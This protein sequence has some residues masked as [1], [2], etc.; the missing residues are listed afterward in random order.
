M[1]QKDRTKVIV[2]GRPHGKKGS[3]N[4]PVY[5]AST[6]LFPT[7]EEFSHYGDDW[8]T[9]MVYG[10]HG[11]PTQFALQEALAQ[12]EGGYRTWLLP[13]GLAAIAISLLAFVK[14]G[15]HLLMPDSVY[16]PTRRFCDQWLT[17]FGIN[18][19]Y[20]DPLIGGDIEGLCTARTSV[21]FVE[22]PGSLTF[23]VQDVP[24]IASAAHR[25][26]ATVLMDNTWATPLFFKPFDHGVDVSIQAATKYI[27]GHSDVMLGAITATQDAWPRIGAAV[28]GFGQQ[29][30]P[31]DCY[32]AL[33]GLRTL[34]VRL[35]RH[36]ATALTLAHW[37]T[38]QAQVA[39]IMHPA[40]PGCQGHDLWR[41]DYR[42][43]S[44]LFGVVLKPVTDDSLTAFLEGLELF[45][46]G[47]SWGGF[48]SLL[49]PVD[50][51]NKR[52]TTVLSLEGPLLRLHAGLE[53]PDDLIAD[54]A[55]GLARL[56]P[57]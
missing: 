7:R 44:G 52:T 54:L 45:G 22:S 5:H 55:T 24:A 37:L 46:M 27:S 29:A 9:R 20:Y 11:T 53:D 50:L 3:V 40:L 4:P 57:K 13:S 43:A 31:D 8:G 23:E 16:D 21:V 42:G 1:Q 38:Q 35:E 34:A 32:L 14:A 39:R 26:G 10:R 2:E 51:S 36:Q 49:I 47:Y 6:V 56:V 12:L 28:R 17:S 41:R 48:E 30:A 25:H 18:T 33:R 19:T 15:D